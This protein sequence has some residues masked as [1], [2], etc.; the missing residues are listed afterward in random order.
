MSSP[1]RWRVSW[2][3][4]LDALAFC[5]PLTGQAFYARHY[6]DERAAFL[7]R[8]DPA[9]V[10]TL[11]GLA[12]DSDSAD[13][14]LWPWLALVFSGGPH[15]TL[16]DLVDSLHAAEAVLQAPFRASAWWSDNSWDRFIGMRPRL[17]QVLTGLQAAGF[18][19]FWRQGQGEAETRRLDDLRRLLS[20]LDIV[21]EQER[22]LGR[23]LPRDLRVTLLQF[24]RPH[25][26]RVQGLHFI[27]HV[28]ATDATML[29]IAAHEVLH[30]P[31]D[32]NGA[33][34]REALAVLAQDPLLKRVLAEKPRETGYND[35]AGLFEE[36]VVQALDQIVQQRLGHGRDPGERWRDADGGLH[37]LA[38]AFHGLLT[39]DAF[40]RD[41]GCIEEWLGNAVRSGLLLPARWQAA[42]ADVLGR[43][44]EALWRAPG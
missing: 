34:A 42:A 5:G 11:Q 36:G 10:P 24:C 13:T 31:F 9:V 29:M 7:P 23:S 43:P 27:A 40:D 1:T 19:A 38:A 18:P 16:A 3:E 21:A 22:L 37:L 26:V 14:L 39:A 8:L 35:L 25:G 41:G 2:S 32:M 44:V 20:S 15:D 33:V 28:M 4:G 6:A 12:A 30:P 17:L